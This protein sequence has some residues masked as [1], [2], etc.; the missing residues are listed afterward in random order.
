LPDEFYKIETE[1]DIYNY[2]DYKIATEDELL[3][4]VVWHSLE[5]A[6][7][8]P[9]QTVYLCSLGDAECALARW[10][11]GSYDTWR[12]M[13]NRDGER[14]WSCCALAIPLTCQ[15]TEKK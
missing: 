11:Q 14:C 4:L 2:E 10:A 7:L 9:F 6:A 5:A 1:D 13:S 15:S 3:L 12:W 8:R